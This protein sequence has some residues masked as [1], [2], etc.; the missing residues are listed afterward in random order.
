MSFEGFGELDCSAEL[1][2]PVVY[3]PHQLVLQEVLDVLGGGEEAWWVGLDDDI[4]E[5]REEVVCSWR[6]PD[7]GILQEAYQDAA[8]LGYT[9]HL[10]SG[11]LR[12]R[13]GG[14]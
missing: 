1:D 11:R 2:P 9:V 13:G 7:L 8:A 6:T 10:P 14:G 12:E 3:L 5:H 4:H